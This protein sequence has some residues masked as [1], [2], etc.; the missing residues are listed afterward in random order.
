[1]RQLEFF[2]SHYT[3]TDTNFVFTRS[4]MNLKSK[5]RYDDHRHFNQVP[6]SLSLSLSP[7]ICSASMPSVRTYG[8]WLMGGWGRERE[9][10]R[11]RERDVERERERRRERVREREVGVVGG[12]WGRQGL[13]AYLLVLV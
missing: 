6:R 12:W 10:E 11:E 5:M 2:Q 13:R 3:N 8:S 4:C 1:M 7:Y 9:R